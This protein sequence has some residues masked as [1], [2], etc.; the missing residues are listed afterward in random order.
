[1]RNC[2]Q[3]R[4]WHSQGVHMLPVVAYVH[5]E[6]KEKY[7]TVD[8]MHPLRLSP[9]RLD[10]ETDHPKLMNE[11]DVEGSASE[12]CVDPT[13]E[14]RWSAREL[15]VKV[16]MGTRKKEMSVLGGARAMGFVHN[17]GKGLE[18]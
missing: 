17:R 9:Q 11:K 13:R 18:T 14:M 1:M 8:E 12:A 5:E 3:S 6:H 16:M 2:E 4:L 10:N 15:G 7:Q